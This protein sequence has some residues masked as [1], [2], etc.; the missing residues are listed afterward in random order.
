MA[1]DFHKLRK[2]SNIKTDFSESS[3]QCNS[4]LFR[5]SYDISATPLRNSIWCRKEGKNRNK[6]F[7]KNT[8]K[9]EYSV[10]SK[11]VVMNSSNIKK[12][13]IVKDK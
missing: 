7:F 2:F 10:K 13:M 5:E 11:N 6:E 1:S 9:H 8:L 3:V 4:D 12:K